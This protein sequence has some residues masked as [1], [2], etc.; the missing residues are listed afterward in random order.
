MNKK[1]FLF[2]ALFIAFF[3]GFSQTEAQT[4]KVEIGDS[5][6]LYKITGKN[7]KKPSYLLGTFHLLCDKDLFP[8]ETKSYGSR[9]GWTENR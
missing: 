3:A 4:S 6:L 9:F 8:K 5:G 2:F 7:L 1:L